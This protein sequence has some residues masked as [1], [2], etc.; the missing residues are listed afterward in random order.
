MNLLILIL[1]ALTSLAPSSERLWPRYMTPERAAVHVT[2]AAIAGAE[3]GIDPALLIAM[4]YVE[5][6]FEPAATSRVEGGRRVTGESSAVGPVG[7]GPRFCGVLQAQAGH[8][9]PRCL[10]LRGVFA[11]YGAGAA[12][13]RAWLRMAGGDMR[14]ALNGHGCGVVALDGNGCNGYGDR[15]LSWARR[16]RQAVAS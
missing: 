13:L 2:A 6:R 8:D 1:T 12:E 3:H 11:G 15:V 9:W 10:E 7:K 14:T 4:A 5:S 16:L